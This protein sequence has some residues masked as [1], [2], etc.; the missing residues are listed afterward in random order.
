MNTDVANVAFDC[1]AFARSFG[2]LIFLL[3]RVA[4]LKGVV[5]KYVRLG[6]LQI[7]FKGA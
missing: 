4:F 1:L 6:P 3:V 5:F 7:F 2:E